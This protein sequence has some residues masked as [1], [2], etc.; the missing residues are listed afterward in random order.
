MLTTAWT[1]R[2]SCAVTACTH[3]V[4]GSGK[5]PDGRTALRALLFG[6]MLIASMPALSGVVQQVE[7]RFT[8]SA[9]TPIVDTDEIF[10]TTS[11]DINRDIVA[12]TGLLGRYNVAAA[13]GRF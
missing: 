5:A 13:A 4:A 1:E 6:E 8:P 10:G 12:Q 7:T 11:G 9:G 2:G 3:T